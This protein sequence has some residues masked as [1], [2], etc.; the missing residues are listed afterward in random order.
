MF[1]LLLWLVASHAEPHV[2]VGGGAEVDEAARPAVEDA[3]AALA[4]GRFDEAARAF[5]GLADASRGVELRYLETLARYEAG[6]LR[7]AA[8]SADR[9]LATDPRHGPLL[10]L[11]GLI[12]ADAGEGEQALADLERAS[13]RAREAG[14]VP[15]QAR[16]TLNEGLV[17]MDL[18]DLRKAAA[19]FERA[20]RLATTAGD[21]DV[22]AAVL[23]NRAL[24]S[25][26]RGDGAASDLVGRVGDALRRGQVA[27]A[28]ALLTDSAPPGR[29]R[30]LEAK[31]AQ[32]AVERAEGR[33]DE[34]AVTLQEALT[35]AREGG[36]ERDRA[37]VLGELGT[38][39]LLA[40][41]DLL[42]REHLREALEVVGDSSFLMLA[43]DLH[44]QAGIV[45]IGLDD[46]TAAAAHLESGRGIAR[47]VES[48]MGGAR[49]DELAGS[50]AAAKGDLAAAD[51]S[52]RAAREA[53]ERRGWWLD[54]ARVATAA[55]RAH[56]RRGSAG[57]AAWEATALAAFEKAG[58]TLG[59][60][61]V[62]IAR[63]L[64]QAGA[65]DLE[66][67]LTSFVAAA[68]AA[69]AAGTARGERL[70]ALARSN[71]AEALRVLGHGPEA[72][73]RA[74]SL[75][76]D[77]ILARQKTLAAARAAWSEGMAAWEEGDF[78]TAR[79]RFDVAFLGFRELGE[80]GYAR[81]ARRGR[82]WAT[83]NSAVGLPPARAFPFYEEI[84]QE[85][86]QVDD[87]ELRVRARSAQ[88][89]AAIDLS[90]VDPLPLLRTCAEDAVD[91]GMEALAARCHA[92][93]AEAAPSLDVRARAARRALELD[94]SGAAS[95]YAMYSV[96]VDAFNAEQFVLA[97]EIA[98]A[99]LPRAG[100]LGDAVTAVLE[101]ARRAQTGD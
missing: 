10:S 36:L 27:E 7:G 48:P 63:G 25:A 58:E 40:G 12:R 86:I 33:L 2:E 24:I 56:A 15:L 50:V 21:D 35:L 65:K 41:R 28:R 20:E 51:T 68:E 6:D 34:A 60:A 4:A 55:A 100:E 70:A 45:A 19:A 57:G 83:W 59:P 30:A 85:A 89:L 61:H 39:H 37:R 23:T 16:V 97:A 43:L 96:A 62:G 9:G 11:R 82:A 53:L 88:A 17:W 67:A 84:V 42:A 73:E 5:A 74:A 81:T 91:V 22:R 54:A 99:V 18:G 26:L 66:G 47:Q 77:G 31:V 38:V 44:A 79:I 64:G 78:T 8:R 71:A 72:A 29:R 1:I 90:G 95:V 80:E 76:L 94:P 69:D 49:L 92:G 52:W 75:G 14:D 32:G 87:P 3:L 93:I 101:A 46:L 98:T 13:A